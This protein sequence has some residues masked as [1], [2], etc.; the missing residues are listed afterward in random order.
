MLQTALEIP[1]QAYRPRQFNVEPCTG[2]EFIDHVPIHLCMYLLFPRPNNQAPTSLNGPNGRHNCSGDP[3]TVIAIIPQ[4]LVL[5]LSPL[6]PFRKG[7][8]FYLSLPAV[9]RI[10]SFPLQSKK[11]SQ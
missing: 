3:A 9:L 8:W 7:H 11:G 4:A 1:V 10:L 6:F 2:S 5:A